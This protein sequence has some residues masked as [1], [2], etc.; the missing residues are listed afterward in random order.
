[1]FFCSTFIHKSVTYNTITNTIN[2]FRSNIFPL[3]V[4]GTTLVHLHKCSPLWVAIFIILIKKTIMLTVWCR[5]AHS[6]WQRTETFLYIIGKSNI[7]LTWTYLLVIGIKGKHNFK[8]FWYIPIKEIP[9]NK[10]ENSYNL[11]ISK[12]GNYMPF[13]VFLNNRKM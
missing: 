8:L 11:N 12:L 1:M 9:T 7:M 3:L 10:G 13:M 5:H 2:T 4:W 6:N